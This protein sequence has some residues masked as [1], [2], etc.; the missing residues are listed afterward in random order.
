MVPPDSPRRVVKRDGSEQPFDILRLTETL[1][2]CLAAVG[3]DTLLAEQFSSTLNVRLESMAAVIASEQLAMEVVSMLEEYGCRS[4]AQAY[5]WYR[6]EEERLV[7]ELRV[8]SRKGEKS[9]S[10]PWDRERLALSLMRDRYLESSLSREVARSAER[11]LVAMGMRH[12]TSRLVAALCENECR[13]RGLR[14]DPLRSE[15]VGIGRR[16]LRAWLG[17][18]CMPGGGADHAPPAL[19][20]PG[21]DPRPV[22]GGELLARFA[23]EE[24]LSNRLQDRW[25]AGE[26]DLLNLSDWLRPVRLW[27]R[28]EQGEAE[29]SFFR[30]VAEARLEAHEVQVFLPDGFPV[31]SLTRM[32]PEWLR[33]PGV[34]LRWSTADA[35]VAVA[36]AHAGHWH[37]MPA[38]RFLRTAEASRRQLL[39]HA[40]TTLHWQPSRRLSAEAERCTRVLH[41]AAVVNCATPALESGPLAAEAYLARLREGADAAC[42]ALVA[43]TQRAAGDTSR[44][45]SL[46]PAGLDLAL[47]RL[48]P[49]PALRQAGARQL[50][51]AIRSLFESM[52][53]R[54]G[55]QLEHSHP[56]HPQ[57]IGARLAE[58]ANPMG[59][60]SL[61]IGWLPGGFE[62]EL[63]ALGL[64]TAP[65]LELPASKL[66]GSPLAA[67][68]SPPDPAADA[69]SRSTD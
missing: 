2:A 59:K 65:W 3:E 63:L 45:V 56:P 52:A 20:E 46:L 31:T 33:A 12:L 10:A 55:L 5:S 43:L 16:Q 69:E 37:T 58:R 67:R 62:L 7:Q 35:K 61:R 44:R 4:A 23:L 48:Y 39:N 25:R 14:G 22:L 66:E 49:D 40:V 9:R 30:R 53:T 60:R 26:Y 38:G 8:H 57:G 17:G 11:R 18:E 42:S 47:D 1:Q 54:Q 68:F 41:G 19:G 64:D 15:Q 24:V 51:L 6:Q 27:L 21:Q 36:W 28:P 29:A 34:R 32:A 50:L 13:M